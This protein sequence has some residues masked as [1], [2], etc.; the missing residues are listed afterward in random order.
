MKT[1]VI[2]FLS[3][4]LLSTGA[5]QAQANQEC[6]TTASLAYSDAKAKNYEAAYPR[7]Q[8]LRKDCPT[9][10]V[11]TYQYGERVL[12]DKLEKAPA[13]EKKAIAQDLIKLYEERLQYFPGKTKAGEV[14]ADVAQ[15]MYDY[16]LGT[17]EEQ[18]AAFDKAYK[19]DKDA[20]N[21]K[22]LYTYFSLLVDLQDAGKKDLQDVF[23][24]YDVVIA[25]VEEEE[26][27]MA[28][29]LAKL[30]EKQEAGEKLTSKEE[31]MLNAYEI[32]LKAYST[33]RGSINAKL[34]QR[35]DCDNLI[36]L[37]NKDFEANKGD[38]EW[39]KRAAGRLSGKDCTEDPLFF[40]LVEALHK[41][42]P[43]A[44]SALYLGQL[45]DA[46]GKASKA[47]EYYNQSAELE[48]NPSDKARVYYRIADEYKR[49][50]QFG[51][52]RNYYRK[53]LQALPSYG[54]A[55]LQIANMIAQSANNCGNTAFEKRAVYW[56]AADYAARA[57]RVD[58]SISSTAN[59]TAAAYR[60]RAPQR[61]DIFQSDMQGKTIN[62]GCWIGESVR[63]PNL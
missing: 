49:K 37:Y 2:L 1:K 63:V 15:V 60:G 38:V 33:V 55:Y 42:E 29:G 30:I 59:E 18:Y 14:Y 44:K 24:Q 46:E 20:L 45:A 22:S 57:G 62:I 51:Q 5:L 40:K 56:L 54:R 36:P 58:P 61:S 50:G 28:E 13:G 35:A 47:L 31:K 19:E 9:Y 3:G 16:K 48:T 26:N 27:K 34:G 10:S 41:A 21:A 43:S 4:V 7:I 23:S 17:P 32:N 53:T 12:K 6:A 39:L 25:K 8:T 52:A 11:V